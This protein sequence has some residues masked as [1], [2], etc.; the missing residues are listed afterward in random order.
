M[1]VGPGV[2][3]QVLEVYRQMKG[4]CGDYQLLGFAHQAKAI[5]GAILPIPGP[6]V[7]GACVS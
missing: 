6:F 4:L 7:S 5:G 2:L 1:T 3:R